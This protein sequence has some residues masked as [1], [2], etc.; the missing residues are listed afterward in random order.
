[1]GL[2][3]RLLT[4]PLAPVE[5]VVWIAQQLEEQ[6][7]RELY[8]PDNIRRQLDDLQ[9]AV[10]AGEISEEEYLES[11]AVLLDRLEDA[12]MAAPLEEEPDELKRPGLDKD[13]N[14]E[15]TEPDGRTD[16]AVG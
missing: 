9:H 4:L 3:T 1:M 2:F 11:E 13:N 10:D 12:F 7:Y 6:A 14:F 16:R 8:N 5:G 15:S